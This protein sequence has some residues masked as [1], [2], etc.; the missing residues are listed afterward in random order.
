MAKVC[1]SLR[2]EIQWVVFEPL[3]ASHD[4]VIVMIIDALRADYVFNRSQSCHLRSIETFEQNGQALAVKLR[5]HS[6]TV[7]LPRLKVRKTMR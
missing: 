6:P 1:V 3:E 4:H 2:E 7:T 5:S